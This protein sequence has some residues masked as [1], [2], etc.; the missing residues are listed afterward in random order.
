[1]SQLSQAEENYLKNIYSLSRKAE[2]VSTRTLAQELQSK[3][4]SVTDM[5]KRL[6]KKSLINYVKYKGVSLTENGLNKALMIIR[7]HRLWE[8]FLVEK[9][10]FNWDEV[11]ELAEQLEHIQSPALIE[12]LDAYLD[13]PEIDPH[14]DPIP[15]KHGEVSTRSQ[16]LLS[17]AN[18][19][20]MLRIIRVMDDSSE[21]LKYL[22]ATGIAIGNDLSIIKR[23]PFDNSLQIRFENGQ[24]IHISEKVSDNIVV[25]LLC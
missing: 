23:I 18:I 14:G 10:Q 9:L 19:N 25:A 4:S 21:F 15:D 13:Y 24:E 11:H 8:V 17:K 3:D 5:L 12:R 7:R 6:A 22:D 2:L 1:M 16:L 20:Q